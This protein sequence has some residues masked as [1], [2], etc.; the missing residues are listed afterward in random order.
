M[1]AIEEID[2]VVT[3]LADA[4]SALDELA[5][6]AELERIVREVKTRLAVAALKTHLPREVGEALGMSRQAAVKLYGRPKD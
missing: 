1:G 5:A 3:K 2:E 6:V 4:D